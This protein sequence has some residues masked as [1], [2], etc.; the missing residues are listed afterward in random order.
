MKNKSKFVSLLFSGLFLGLLLSSS[1]LTLTQAQD[2]APLDPPYGHVKDGRAPRRPRLPRA[3][4]HNDVEAVIANQSSVK[5]QLSRGTCSI[6]SATALLESMLLINKKADK[7]IDLSEEYLEY[8]VNHDSFGDGS[9]SYRN[10]DAFFSYGTANEIEF[11]YIGETWKKGD[12]TSYVKGE[13]RCGRFEKNENSEIFDR[14]LVVHRDPRLLDKDDTLLEKEGGE[15]YDP[16]FLKARTSAEKFKEEYMD[17]SSNHDAYR[18]DV[19]EAK[20]LLDK[21]IPLT[22]DLDFYYGAW[23]HRLAATLGMTRN[24]QN[25]DLGIVGYPEKGSLDL[26]NSNS[27]EERAGHSIV[28]VGYDDKVKLEIE[29]EMVDKTKKKST[30]TGVYYFK[31]SWG[32]DKLGSQF[33]IKD[34]NGKEIPHPGY[35]M[36]TQKYA[37]EFGVFFK[38][39]LK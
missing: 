38:L 21:G 8:L 35:A 25:W 5:S 15:F 1:S 30:Y 23:N 3:T 10:F 9:S 11:G 16:E 6:F 19:T 34:K 26:I 4:H 22:L 28:V 7:S 33:K 20:N 32:T 2:E 31:N 17:P 29:T 36:I 24:M 27:P 13:E 18:V 37:E 39:P 14:C 12:Y